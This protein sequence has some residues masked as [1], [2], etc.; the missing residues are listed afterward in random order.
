M[1]SRLLSG[2]GYMRQPQ[3]LHEQHTLFYRSSWAY[4][5]CV[6]FFLLCCF[7]STAR[8]APFDPIIL[9]VYGLL[10]GSLRE[11]DGAISP[12]VSL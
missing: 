12:E 4:S 3:Q 2:C 8:S 11:H 6:L 9:V 1:T 7:S 10:R 5:V